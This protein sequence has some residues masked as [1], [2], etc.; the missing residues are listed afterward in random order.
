MK[1][2]IFLFVLSFVVVTAFQKPIQADG[3]QA[4]QKQTT[5]QKK[6]W[7]NYCGYISAACSGTMTIKIA[8]DLTGAYVLELAVNGV[9]IS[10]SVA[11]VAP[12]A[13]SPGVFAVNINYTCNGVWTNYTGG[14]YTWVCP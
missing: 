4:A 2:R 12:V 5:Q 7:Q 6:V 9:P 14:A 13:G 8:S 3:L 10:F 11:S 1:T